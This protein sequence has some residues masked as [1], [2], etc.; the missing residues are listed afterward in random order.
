MPVDMRPVL[1]DSERRFEAAE[2]DIRPVLQRRAVPCV[3]MTSEDLLA[4]PLDGREGFV[5]SLVD[6]RSDVET[7]VDIAG[8]PEEE[9]IEIVLK[10]CYL[11]AIELR[12]P[13]T[14]ASP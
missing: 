3:A 12:D 11:G 1:R 10:L 13:P 9:T 5:L 6:G 4:L 14:A 7:I 2:S 8:L